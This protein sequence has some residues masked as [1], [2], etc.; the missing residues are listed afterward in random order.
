[1]M[2]IDERDVRKK[3]FKWLTIFFEMTTQMTVVSQTKTPA[4]TNAILGKHPT[5]V[6]ERMWAFPCA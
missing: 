5:E 3:F 4:V 1:M 6:M 2:K